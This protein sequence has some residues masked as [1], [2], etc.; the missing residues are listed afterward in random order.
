MRARSSAAPLRVLWVALALFA[1]VYAHGVS[2]DGVAGHLTTGA[3]ASATAAGPAHDAEQPPVDHHGPVD[4]YGGAEH[5]PSHPTQ[6][7]VPGQPKQTPALDA[8]GLGAVVERQQSPAPQP[9]P[10]AF[11]DGAP[12]EHPP[13]SALRATVLRI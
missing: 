7:C 10:G 9:A 6:D 13:S 2:I 1:F 3:T 12:V 11:R 5:G 4:H 8:P